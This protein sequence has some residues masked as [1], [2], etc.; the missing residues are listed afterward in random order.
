[1]A[2]TTAR[3]VYG[4]YCSAAV[5]LGPMSAVHVVSAGKYC[6]RSYGNVAEIDRNYCLWVLSVRPPPRALLPFKR[7][8]KQ[9]H[10]GVL[11][12]GKHRMLFFDE[13]RLAAMYS[14]FCVVRAGVSVLMKK[15]EVHRDAP[16][17]A[18]WVCGLTDASAPLLELKEYIQ[19]RESSALES[20]TKR[21]RGE[22]PTSAVLPGEPV[23]S[24]MECKVCFAEQ[25]TT[26]FLPC[27]H[28]VCC[29]TCASR[30]DSCPLCRRDIS[31]ILR[32]FPG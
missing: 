8:L 14:L 11:P 19:E 32:V 17:Y 29:Q 16:E 7:W 31:D 10:G 15:R 18:A 9:N 26:V 12:Y 2:I 6:G 22:L 30:S 23:P 3:V 21:A 20:P 25:I 1:M 13:A 24:S 4:G 27:R 28:L 5:Q